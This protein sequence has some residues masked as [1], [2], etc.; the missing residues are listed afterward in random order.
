MSLQSSTRHWSGLL[1]ER[2]VQVTQLAAEKHP[3]ILGTHSVVVV[4]LA[5]FCR[6]QLGS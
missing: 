5:V 3:S 2:A 1:D 4:M 6:S